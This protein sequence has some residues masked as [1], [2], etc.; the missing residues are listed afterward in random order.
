MQQPQLLLPRLSC[1]ASR[2]L[3]AD[4]SAAAGAAASGLGGKLLGQQSR[5]QQWTA[6]SGQFEG[7]VTALNAVVTPLAALGPLLEAAMGAASD[8]AS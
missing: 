2:P 5:L 4:L 1:G 3:P 6:L 7:H 8:A